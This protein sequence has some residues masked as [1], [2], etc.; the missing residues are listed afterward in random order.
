MATGYR[1]RS[2]DY[3]LIEAV[4]DLAHGPCLSAL[5]L[6]PPAG[7]GGGD[8]LEQGG[9]DDQRRDE[10]DRELE[11]AH[12]REWVRACWMWMSAEPSATS[13]RRRSSAS[14]SRWSRSSISSILICSRLRSRTRR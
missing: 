2:P 3:P 8:E 10:P 12:S 13:A 9:A 14:I 1:A 4:L 7:A 5:P 11:Q 6:A